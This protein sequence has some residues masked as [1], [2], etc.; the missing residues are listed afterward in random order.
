MS[1]SNPLNEAVVKALKVPG[2][3]ESGGAWLAK[4]LH[5]S[6]A[7]LK[8]NGIPED[9]S[10]PTAALNFMTTQTI[11]APAAATWS[12]H[13]K[14]APTPCVFGRTA[15]NTAAAYGYFSAVNPTL[16]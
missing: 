1:K 5:P 2:I 4:A 10:I 6:D 15:T 7:T 14:L 9:T 12:A 8:C 11:T 13:I 16:T 3:T